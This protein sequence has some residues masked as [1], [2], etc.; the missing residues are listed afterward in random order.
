[1]GE[2]KVKRQLGNNLFSSLLAMIVVITTIFANDVTGMAAV[3]P[4]LTLSSRQET[5]AAGKS[6][7]LKVKTVKGLKSKSV[8]WKS[9]NTKVAK[10]S[11]KGKVTGLKA[12]NAKITATSKVNK[13]VK[14]T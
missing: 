10:V 12:G 7:Q 1:M 9:S 13:K 6:V 2:K 4:K 5:I 8:T 3:K 11:S 14:A